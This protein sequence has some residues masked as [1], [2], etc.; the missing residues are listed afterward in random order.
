MEKIGIMPRIFLFLS[1]AGLFL[2]LFQEYY[3]SGGMRAELGQFTSDSSSYSKFPNWQD[4][5]NKPEQYKID[6]LH[7]DFS[8]RLDYSAKNIQAE[9]IITLVVTENINTVDLNFG[10]SLK[11]GELLLNGK[12]VQYKRSGMVLSVLSSSVPG[13]TIQVKISY[14]GKPL[15]Q[16]DGSFTWQGFN[17]ARVIS[18]L[19]EPNLNPSWFICNDRPD[20]KA[21]LDIRITNDT[22]FT[23]VSNGS[24]IA[25]I[26]EG[27]QKTY[28]WRSSYPVSTYLIALYSGQYERFEDKYV[29][30]SGDTIPIEYYVVPSKRKAAETAFARHADMFEFMEHTIGEY[31]F[32]REKYGVAG[33]N[34]QGGAMENQTIT[35]VGHSLI[36]ESS[37]METT[38][39]H[40]LAHHWF[41]NSVGPKTWRDIWLNEGFASYF[42]GLYLIYT[43][44]ISDISEYMAGLRRIEYPD[45]MYNPGHDEIFNRAVYDKGAW[46]LHALRYEIGDSLF[47]RVLKTYYET[48]KYSNASTQDFQYICEM[49]SGTDLRRFFNQYVYYGNEIPVIRYHYAVEKQGAVYQTTI[50]FEQKNVTEPYQVKFDITLSGEDQTSDE[51]ILLT[52]WSETR[53]FKTRYLPKKILPDKNG[54]FIGL[55]VPAK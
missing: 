3:G 24:L 21:L 13:D 12:E 15:N 7:Y 5:Y 33:F 36:D 45:K 50:V 31:P 48:Y 46:V 1:L 14:S 22:S 39:L 38:Y 55:I 25:V 11:I 35:G 29:S 32:K 30:A 23:S 52:D 44:Q 17:G 28:H 37:A 18:T 41:G 4:L 9:S 42:E 53:V 54:N 20:D 34:W 27:D 2:S 47:F 40:E 8:I 26:T 19:G 6:V 16:G 43:G 51:R 10:S 49:V